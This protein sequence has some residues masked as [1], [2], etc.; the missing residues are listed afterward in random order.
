VQSCPAPITGRLLG[1]RAN[2]LLR[3]PDWRYRL[4]LALLES[5]REP[6]PDADQ[7]L[8]A[9]YRLVQWLRQPGAPAPPESEALE[10]YLVAM[11][12]HHAADDLTRA[13]LEAGILARRTPAVAAEAVGLP[14]AVGEAYAA[15]FF[16]VADRLHLSG[17]ITANMHCLCLPPEPTLA[18][19]LRVYAAA[20][21]PLVLD[22]LLHTFGLGQFAL[23]PHQ[24][25]DDPALD[26]LHWRTGIAIRLLP[27]NLATSRFILKLHARLLRLE[28]FRH[29][30]V[31]H[32]QTELKL[33]HSVLKSARRLFGAAVRKNPF[34]TMLLALDKEK[35]T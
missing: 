9:L 4:A 13:I 23:T 11:Q 25:S 24:P 31:R 30:P 14:T 33:L 8:L 18:A 35:P 29:D 22:D 6:S 2:S 17:Y 15:A 21:G 1:L 3:P 26:A 10:P 19:V 20:G 34:L 16:D 27:N 5:G 12:I 32:R 28:G 7:D